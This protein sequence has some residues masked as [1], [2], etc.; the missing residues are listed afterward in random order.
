[1]A[2]DQRATVT[3]LQGA[4]DGHE[5]KVVDLAAAQAA[6]QDSL[7]AILAIQQELDQRRLA[8]K[9]AI[10]FLPQTRLPIRYGFALPSSVS[11]PSKKKLLSNLKNQQLDLIGLRA[12]SPTQQ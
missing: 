2:S 12:G 1:M 9:R 4:V 3:A 7:T 6:R 8:L 11:P 5:K 10:G